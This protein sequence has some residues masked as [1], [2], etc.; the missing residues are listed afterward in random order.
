VSSASEGG[1][2]GGETKSRET[3]EDSVTSFA[4][5]RERRREIDSYIGAE[6][7]QQMNA[8][9]TL[10]TM[11]EE[12][13]TKKDVSNAARASTIAFLRRA[14][15]RAS[16]ARRGIHDDPDDD[17]DSEEKKNKIN[18]KNRKKKKKKRRVPHGPGTAL[19]PV[20]RVD[21]KP[22]GQSNSV[23]F[24]KLVVGDFKLWKTDILD[25][26][27]SHHLFDQFKLTLAAEIANAVGIG[28]NRVKIW[29]VEDVNPYHDQKWMH[30]RCT[31]IHTVPVR[32]RSR[33]PR[34][35]RAASRPKEGYVV[36][37]FCIFCIL[38]FV[39]LLLLRLFLVSNVN[40]Y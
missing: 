15:C 4:A 3:K 38:Y 1:V 7:S 12:L 10:T 31:M 23:D 16:K 2:M 24:G 32:F 17:N 5:S 18:R 35:L 20:P 37:V 25:V 19:F 11:Q 34:H 28:E 14:A 30:R 8:D 22:K 33:L 21:W 29:D 13:T 26:T 39:F 40:L 9:A 6:Q 36:F 27:F